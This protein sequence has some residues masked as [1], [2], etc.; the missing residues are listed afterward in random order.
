MDLALIVLAL[1]LIYLIFIKL[2]LKETI[3]WTEWALNVF[4][5]VVSVIAVLEFSKYIQHHDIEIWNGA[6][7]SKH[8]E[9]VSCTHSYSCDCTTYKNSDGSTSESCATCYKH[10]FDVDWIVKT[11]A[12]NIKIDRVDEQG[13]VEPKRYSNVQIGEAASLEHRFENYIKAV[14]E[15]LFNDQNT[16]IKSIDRVLPLYP[17]VFDYYK[18]NRVLVDA[19]AIDAKY[20]SD[21]NAA[22]NAGLKELGSKKEVNV[23]VV[24][25]DYPDGF[26]Y[27]DSLRS[28]WLNGKKNDVVVL[29]G[30][31][32]NYEVKWSHVFGWSK[33]ELTNLSISEDIIK[34]KKVDD[35][36][37]LSSVILSN[38]EKYFERDSMQ[39][40]EYLKDSI[41][42]PLWVILLAL[43]LGLSF[44]IGLSIYFH[45]SIR[46]E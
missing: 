8:D 39:N 34:L 2:Y 1:P 32:E 25:T 24:L 5:V 15:S 18:I 29:I 28:K 17:K 4:I 33:N 6:V 36:L 35:A 30:V 40:Y 37:N 7:V 16:S 41:E 19:Q 27:R 10:D 3:T 31:G 11:T 9:K 26:S 42:P 21:L 23:I 12:G 38:I 22:L 44:S 20:V 45:K 13:I 43:F 14:P 46:F